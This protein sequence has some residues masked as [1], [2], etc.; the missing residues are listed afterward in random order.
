[1]TRETNAS[2]GP[3]RVTFVAEDAPEVPRGLLARPEAEALFSKYERTGDE[4]HFD[5]FAYHV[6]G[7]LARVREALKEVGQ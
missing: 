1:M 7:E 3:Q 5:A 4:S 6:T 2:S